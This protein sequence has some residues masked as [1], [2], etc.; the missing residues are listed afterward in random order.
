M[1]L[2]FFDLDLEDQDLVAKYDSGKAERILRDLQAEKSPVYRGTHVE[3]F[4]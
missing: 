1:S 2:C 3:A 4:T